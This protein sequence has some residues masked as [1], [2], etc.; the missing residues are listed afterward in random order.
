MIQI[1]VAD[2]TNYDVNGDAVLL[3]DTCTLDTS[4]W[5][6]SLTHPRDADGRWELIQDGAVLK[7]PTF[8]ADDQ[9]YRIINTEVTDSG[10]TATAQPIFFDSAGD[11]M[12]VDTRPIDK[13]GQA[14]LDILTQGTK[15][16]GTSDI[17]A[18]STAY[19]QMRNLMEALT[20]DDDNAFVNRWGG[21]V[22]YDNYTVIIN[23]RLGADN[24][25]LLAYGKNIPADGMRITEDASALVTRIYPR[26][27]NGR[28]LSGSGYV[29]SPLVD[30][31]PTVH[32][33]VMEF[34]DVRLAEDV[35]GDDTEGL[36]VCEDQSALDEALRAKCAAQW[37]A[38]V[39]KP[40][41]TVEVSMVLLADTVNYADVKDLERVSLGDTVHVRNQRLGIDMSARVKSL[42]YDC[43]RDK[44]QSVTIGS[45]LYDYVSDTSSTIQ[46]ADA[47]IDKGTQT[48]MANR[49]A[50]VINLLTTSLRA[51]KD[52]A[53]RQDVRA[54]LFED[55]DESS[56]T[57]GA[58]CIGTQGIQIA[59]ER[60]AE[61]TDWKWG[62]AID[63]QSVNADY[64]ITGILTDRNGKFYFN[65]DTGELVMAD[66][67]FAG[68]ING[69]AINGGTIQGTT[70]TGTTIN[71]GT[72]SGTT[73]NGGSINGSTL[74]TENSAYVGQSIYLSNND[75][76][77]S[78][79]QIR[80]NKS[81]NQYA[82][83]IHAANSGSLFD[84][85]GIRV[86]KSGSYSIINM[87]AGSTNEITFNIKD[88]SSSGSHTFT[89]TGATID[90]NLQVMG[91]INATGS[92]NRVVKT[93]N[94]GKRLM[95]AVE[96]AD[97]FFED[98]GTAM[99]DA[100]GFCEVQLDDI[101][102][103]TVNTDYDYHVFLTPYS[104]DYASKASIYS[105]SKDRF[106]VYGTPHTR[107]DWRVSAKQRGYEGIRMEVMEDDNN[108]Q[109]R[110]SFDA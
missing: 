15:Y 7:L 75:A 93:E 60:N 78:T 58:L 16:S 96:S 94:Y 87:F 70:I 13:S 47:V 57:Y 88:G 107:F 25:A 84:S 52:V 26:A 82:N 19:Y 35:S 69:S 59:K 74:N 46:A 38:D 67:T 71:G 48:L 29:D 77:I 85:L 51:Q 103:E 92:K 109:N 56:P 24:G 40:A 79:R 63:F 65:L 100:E 105:K 28:A 76:N 99:T 64:I 73:I 90:G 1:Y 102:L 31:Y 32:Q 41:V 43:V 11:V 80:F 23:E 61:G 10:V 8:L 110:S 21:E 54:I 62:T 42:V 68:T 27:Y 89:D 9:L 81:S 17:T 39:D 44:V 95:N 45:A 50:G 106:I 22:M 3:P 91:N 104:D 97:A 53:H 34:S 72:I 30:S 86:Q 83:I 108:D 18:H 2:N 14:A 33:A 5:Q 49:I 6:V 101:F 66:G 20:G 98:F 12:L 4:S 37:A 55:L 36:I